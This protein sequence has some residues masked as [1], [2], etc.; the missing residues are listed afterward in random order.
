MKQTIG[1]EQAGVPGVSKKV[2]PPAKKKTFRNILIKSF[3]MN[4]ANLLAIHIHVYLTIFVNL[5]VY[6]IMALSFF[7]IK[8][9]VFARKM[10]MQSTSFGNDVNFSSS[11]I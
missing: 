7:T 2:A 10:K 3:C 6:F 11:R 5:T 4:F 1:P 8:F 9:K